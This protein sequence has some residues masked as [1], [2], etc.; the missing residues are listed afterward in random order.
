MGIELVA[1][2]F[3]IFFFF[4]VIL[5][6]FLVLFLGPNKQRIGRWELVSLGKEK[7]KI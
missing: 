3:L 7:Q 5:I 1:M 4:F 2:C 6:G